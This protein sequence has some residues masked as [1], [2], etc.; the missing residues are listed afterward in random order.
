MK[1]KIFTAGLL[2]VL[3]LSAF[4]L[5][6]IDWKINE[7][8]SQV[9]WK[10]PGT[11]KEGKFGNLTSTISFDP[12]DLTASKISA[13]IDVKTLNTANDKLTAHLLSPDFFDAEKFPK[14]TFT[15][16]EIKASDK[17]FIAKGPMHMKDSTKTVELPFTFTESK[18]NAA[19]F[20]GT[21]SILPF[22]FGV[23]K[24]KDGTPVEIHLIVPV[25]K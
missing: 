14:V 6:V 17:G 21:M 7:K 4:T 16:T 13:S 1:K 23:T 18:N 3:S 8:E 9:L 15:S 10:I 20:S 2:A 12:K 5:S 22:D 25:T 24:K 11:D 19:V